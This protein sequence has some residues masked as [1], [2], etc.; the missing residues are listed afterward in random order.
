MSVR[1]PTTATSSSRVLPNLSADQSTSHR[2]IL[3]RISHNDAVEAAV[4]RSQAGALSRLRRGAGAVRGVLAGGGGVK[5]AERSS[6]AL[7]TYRGDVSVHQPRSHSSMSTNTTT[8]SGNEAA[9]LLITKRRGMGDI[10]S[11]PNSSCSGSG[12]HVFL[13]SCREFCPLL[14]LARG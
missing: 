11:Q 13:P 8:L 2:R 10:V 3:D 14:C 7:G 4:H 12:A 6:T 9:R 1:Q 5:T